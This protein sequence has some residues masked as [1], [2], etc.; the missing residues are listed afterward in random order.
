M[1]TTILSRQI[2]QLP[3][4]LL[5]QAFPKLRPFNRDEADDV[6]AAFTTW[7]SRHPEHQDSPWREAF[8][9][10]SGATPERVGHVQFARSRCPACYGRRFNRR[11]AVCS[12]CIGGRGVPPVTTIVLHQSDTSADEAG[13]APHA[14]SSPPPKVGDRIRITG[15]MPDDPAPMPVGAEGTVRAVNDSSYLASGIQID[16]AWDNSSRTLMVLGTDPF[17]IISRAQS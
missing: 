15:V 3:I 10:W 2:R 6:C 16:V 8:N 5:A 12:L 4:G 1:S 14:A 17:T 13:E 11:G 7:L 9:A